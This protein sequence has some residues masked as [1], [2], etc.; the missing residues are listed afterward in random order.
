MA[1]WYDEKNYREWDTYPER[2]LRGISVGEREVLDE[3]K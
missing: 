2:I 3:E 1:I